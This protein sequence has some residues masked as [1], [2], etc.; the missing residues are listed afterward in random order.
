MDHLAN[1]ITLP[2][3]GLERRGSMCPDC[4]VVRGDPL[5][6]S[7]ASWIRTITYQCSACGRTWEHLTPEYK[8]SNHE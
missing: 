5:K 7:F 2:R 1:D 4:I 3:P 8:P 6:L